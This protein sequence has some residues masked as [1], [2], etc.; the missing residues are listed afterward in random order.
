[1]PQEFGLN[2]LPKDDRDFALGAIITLPK[3]AELPREF[4]HE[5]LGIKQQ[6]GTDMCTAFST[7]AAS[8]LQEG[9]QL[10]PEYQFA[11]IKELMG[12][13][14]NAFGADL[15]VAMKSHVKIGA[16][17]EKDRPAGFSLTEKDEAILRRIENWPQDLKDKALIHAKGSFFSLTGPYDAFD[18]IRATI[19]HFREEKRVPVYGVRWAWDL[20]E[21]FIK[22]VK[23][24]G[25]GHAIYATGWMESG[26]I[27]YLVIPNSFGTENGD[28]G[29]FYMS[30]EVVNAFVSIYG[31]FI[32]IDMTKE[33]Y[34]QRLRDRSNISIFSQ[35][36]SFFAKILSLDLEIL[37]IKEK[38]KQQIPVEKKIEDIVPANTV[39]PEVKLPEVKQMN[40]PS[41]TQLAK[42]I[43]KYENIG[44]KTLNNPGALRY[45]PFQ[46]GQRVQKSTGKMLAYFATYKQGFDAL[47]YQLKL[48]AT[49]KSPA[50]NKEAKALG[51]TSCS[52]MSISQ[53]FNVY[54]PSNDQNNPDAYA[55]TVA[56]NLKVEPTFKMKDFII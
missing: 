56:T 19:W 15:R 48:V 24:G 41:L 30:R 6:F 7:C 4:R 46:V 45:S 55:R 42:E 37:K 16:I 26:G 22:T 40:R 50:Y 47:I 29:Y 12:G 3:L 32:F 49:G 9:V 17:E 31:A 25:T 1:M 27:P 21:P 38:E 36:L 8:E 11:L 39:Q 13:D 44:D 20:N 53:F 35:I 34:Q 18:N 52:Q 28:N 2:P 23:D 33:E 5:P 51:L 10:V 54:A 43:E 14:I